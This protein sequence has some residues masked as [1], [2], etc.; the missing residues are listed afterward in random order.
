MMSEFIGGGDGDLQAV[1]RG[2]NN[3]FTMDNPPAT[4]FASA[5]TIQQDYDDF[6][7]SAFPD[8]FETTTSTTTTVLD[9]LDELYKP[10]Y[11]VLNLNPLSSPPQTILSSSSSSSISV[12]GGGKREPEKEPFCGSAGDVVSGA[13][14]TTAVGVKYKRRKTQHKRV[15][16]QVTAEGLSSDTWAWRKYGQKPIK[17]SPHPRSYYR[18]S[19]S[20][21]CL[22]R[23][24][25]ERSESDPEM[26]VV[27]YTAE[28]CHSQPTRRSSLAGTTR[29]KFSTPKSSAI[30]GGDS[31]SDGSPISSSAL[32][33]PSPTPSLKKKSTEEEDEQRMRIIEDGQHDDNGLVIYD[34]ILSDDLLLGFDELDRLM[35]SD[36]A[37]NGGF[38]EQ[39]SPMIFPY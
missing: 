26:F 22:A 32:S 8:L 34:M 20:K 3:D 4:C 37:Y 28:H 15:V 27:T 13:A 6:D 12:S 16:L 14:A 29:H 1:V 19:S 10:F 24:Q 36:V 35:N 7:F 39:Y 17:G 31:H 23:K 5:S 38:Q 2:F 30:T 21:G 18:C 9:E 33:P 11:P 25:V